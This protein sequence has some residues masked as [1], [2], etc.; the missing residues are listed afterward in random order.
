MQSFIS[1]LNFNKILF[2]KAAFLAGFSLMTVELTAARILAPYVGSSI[3]T[4]TSVIGVVLFGYSIGSY[5]GGYLIDKYRSKHLIFYFFIAAAFAVVII[6]LLSF[7]SPFLVTVDIPVAAITVI[8]S[9]FLFLAPSVCFG[10]IYPSL[11]KIYSQG[12]DSIGK[13]SGLL[14]AWWSIGSILGT[15]LTGFYFIGFLGTITANIVIGIILFLSG[16]HF[17]RPKVLTLISFIFLFLFLLAAI[18]G[19]KKLSHSK[20]VIF[21]RE[22]DYYKINV[23]DDYSGKLGSAAR[24]LFLDADMHSAESLDGRNLDIYPEIS[25]VFSVF[26]SGIKKILA[27]G[28]GSYYMPKLMSRFYENADI[29]AV[30]IDPAVE[31]TAKDFFGLNNYSFKSVISDGRVFLQKNQQRYDL[32]F[33]DAFNSFLSVPWHLTTYEFNELAKTR[34]SENGVY[35]VNIISSFQGGNSGLFKSFYATF[36]RTF[37]NNYIFAYGSNDFAAQNIILVGVNSSEKIPEAD[38]T[39]KISGLQ[40]GNFLASLLKPSLSEDK[41]SVILS[42]DFSPVENLM[43]PLV[44]GYF[45]TDTSLY[46]S[47]L[48]GSPI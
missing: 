22:S 17:Y 10:A 8:L 26:N 40:N 48:F 31:K 36:S 21:S 18:F 12:G 29:T 41:N 2:A 45:K 14:S 6:P 46:Y 9:A 3:Y 27:I 38:L 7:L 4:W 11:L 28:G 34:L 15:F 20:K 19:I 24:L 1:H 35:A 33:S 30:E 43:R 32:I 44:N 13:D 25:P 16:L 47:L 23:I 37:P 39:S 42:D 5:L